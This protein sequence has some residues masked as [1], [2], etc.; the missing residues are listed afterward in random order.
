MNILIADDHN[1]VREGLKPF[2]EELADSVDILEASSFPDAWD[3]ANSRND[4]SLILLDL[5]MPG[6]NGFDGVIKM[7]NSFQTIPVVVISGHF[8]RQDVLEVIE[9]GAAGYIPKT[10]SGSAMINALR[11]VLSGEK[12]IPSAAFHEGDATE[13][14]SLI[15][16]PP[17]QDALTEGPLSRLSDREKEILGHLIDGNTNKEIARILGLQEI[18]VKV[19]LRNIYRKMEAS[20]RAQAVRIALENGWKTT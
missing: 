17:T 11:L 7:C 1:L 13:D 8:N 19:H 14:A 3:K 16:R 15:Q 18:T 4:I 5:R 6:M 2:L 20:N 10:T 9:C 12:Y